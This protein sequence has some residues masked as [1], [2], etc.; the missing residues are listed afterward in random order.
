VAFKSPL[1]FS[2][3]L[4]KLISQHPLTASIHTF[5]AKLKKQTSIL[6]QSAMNPFSGLYGRAK[7]K[8]FS[9]SM[10]TLSAGVVRQTDKQVTAKN[11]FSGALGRKIPYLFSGAMSAMSARLTRG[12]AKT[13][14]ASTQPMS[15]S[16]VRRIGKTLDAAWSRFKA[17]FGLSS[18]LLPAH[19]TITKRYESRLLIAHHYTRMASAER[20]SRIITAK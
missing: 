16:M 8:F 14:P 3:A 11:R 4:T 15:A 17:T 20:A 6:A 13:L 2:P 12:V 19:R 18:Y 10:N 9:A 7:A 1:R 5:G